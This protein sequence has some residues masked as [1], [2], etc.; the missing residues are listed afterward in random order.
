MVQ[1]STRGNPQVGESS[2]CGLGPPVLRVA[3][4]LPPTSR[5]SPAP[6]TPTIPRPGP[7]ASHAR[8][9]V[10]PGPAE[11][12]EPGQRVRGRGPGAAPPP[13]KAR[14]PPPGPGR[15]PGR[16]RPGRTLTWPPA[17]APAAEGG[18][19][20]GG[21]ACRGRGGGG[22]APRPQRVA[23]APAAPPADWPS[24][25]AG[26]PVQTTGGAWRTS[27]RAAALAVGACALGCPAPAGSQVSARGSRAPAQ[28]L[29]R[30]GAAGCGRER[31]GRMEEGAGV[32]GGAL[33]TGRRSGK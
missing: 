2:S 11:A 19:G 16:R 29:P 26:P 12:E 25:G 27:S 33:G 18:A 4:P 6:P 28:G 15:S 13:H 20:R 17:P 30:G 1:D 24:S 7:R 22:A 8:Q 3:P 10:L 5:P 9:R 21:G 14:R 23:M 31:T 32:R